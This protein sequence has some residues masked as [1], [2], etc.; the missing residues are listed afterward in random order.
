[1]IF[2]TVSTDPDH[3]EQADDALFYRDTLQEL[4]QIGTDLA[5]LLHQNAI[6][7][8]QAAVRD[9][10]P[11]EPPTDHATAFDRLARAIRR[12]ITLARSLSE[13]LARALARTRAAF[14]TP[15]PPGAG[16]DAAAHPA[17][18]VGRENAGAAETPSAGLRDHPETPDCDAPD[19]DE[20]DRDAPDRDAPDRDAPDRDEDDRDEDD[21]GR[22]AAA[23][24]ADICRDLGLDTPPGADA[25]TR[26]TPADIGQ[27]CTRAAPSGATSGDAH[28]SGPGPQAP[29]P[30]SP[31]PQRPRHDAAQHSPGPQPDGNDPGEPAATCTQPAPVQS[32]DTLPDDPAEA[33]TTILRHPADAKERRP[34]PSES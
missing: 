5:R 33:I 26:R 13:P 20:D 10:T 22:P 21:T 16:Q 11:S 7:Q 1:M 2:R 14:C 3:D 24:I 19:C 27:P 25:W 31:W 17:A 29:W 8:A 28:Q 34:P 18:A 23:I 30:Q 6:A 32:G 4:I 9:L 15:T 12:T